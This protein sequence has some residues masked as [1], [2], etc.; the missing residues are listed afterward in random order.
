MS[1][2]G[3]L[4]DSLCKLLYRSNPPMGAEGGER[5]RQENPQKFL[6][7]IAWLIEWQTRTI[8]SWLVFIASLA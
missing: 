5:K 7:Q 2:L 6:G 3:K 4:E 1:F 8:L